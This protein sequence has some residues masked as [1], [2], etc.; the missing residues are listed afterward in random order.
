MIGVYL[1][2]IMQAPTRKPGTL[3]G[4]VSEQQ[5]GTFYTVKDVS[6]VTILTTGLPVQVDDRYIAENN[7]EYIIIK[8][9]GRSATAEIISKNASPQS[10]KLSPSA[11]QMTSMLDNMMPYRRRLPKT[12][13]WSS[14][15]LTVTSHTH[16]LREQP[17]NREKAGYTV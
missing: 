8:V 12:A 2:N 14:I 7:V 6:G 15:I 11:R 4:N 9:N 16:R 3:P 17:V 1:L 5:Q 13:M 10:S